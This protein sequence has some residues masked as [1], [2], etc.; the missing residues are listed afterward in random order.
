M[1]FFATP[2]QIQSILNLISPLPIIPA[3]LVWFYVLWAMPIDRKSY[4]DTNSYY[5]LTKFLIKPRAWSGLFDLKKGEVSDYISVLLRHCGDALSL[6]SS[7]LLWLLY[8]I[9]ISRFS[10]Q[11]P[12]VAGQVWKVFLFIYKIMDNISKIL[13]ETATNIFIDPA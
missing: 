13:K 11:L 10:Q 7:F 2:F 1:L 12:V 8:T 9:F 6:S 5:Y 4:T 3:M